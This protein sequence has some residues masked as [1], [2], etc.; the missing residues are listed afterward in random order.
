MKCLNH[1]YW[2][3]ILRVHVSAEAEQQC[4]V[5]QTHT[6]TQDA[7]L[8]VINGCCYRG[9]VMRLLYKTG[10]HRGLWIKP[11][12][13]L[14]AEHAGPKWLWARWGRSVA[15]KAMIAPTLATLRSFPTG[16]G[17]AKNG[18]LSQYCKKALQ[19]KESAHWHMVP[20]SLW[21]LSPGMCF[22]YS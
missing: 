10:W 7:V 15:Q 3:K 1:K 14:S 9:G 17:R 19:M 22:Q 16:A 13:T 11:N 8:Y 18:T 21:S 4:I 12:W 6:Y 20:P 5:M 2:I